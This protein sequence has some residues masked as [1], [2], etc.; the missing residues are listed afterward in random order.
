[1]SSDDGLLKTAA[2]EFYARELQDHVLKGSKDDRRSGRH[3]LKAW[4]TANKD[5]TES[6]REDATGIVQFSIPVSTQILH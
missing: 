2:A 1:L 5:S 4:T 6:K 3:L